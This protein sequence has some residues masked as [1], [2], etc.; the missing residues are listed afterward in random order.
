MLIW[1]RCCK[2]WRN[3][4]IPI[5]RYYFSAELGY[6]CLFAY[7]IKPGSRSVAIASCSSL[8]VKDLMVNLSV[9]IIIFTTIYIFGGRPPCGRALHLTSTWFYHQRS[10]RKYKKALTTATETRQQGSPDWDIL[11]NPWFSSYSLG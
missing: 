9:S 1:W 11:I 10:L 4:A 7:T 8:L 3:R 2:F 5:P 6:N